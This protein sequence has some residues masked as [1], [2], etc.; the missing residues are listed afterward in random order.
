MLTTNIIFSLYSLFFFIFPYDIKKY[1][2]S[3]NYCQPNKDYVV[4]YKK[5]ELM[6]VSPKGVEKLYSHDNDIKK[7]ILDMKSYDGFN[8]VNK[9][10]IRNFIKT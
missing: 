3:L 2:T 7:W 5:K 10:S 6:M 8:I 4:G 9:F 1:K